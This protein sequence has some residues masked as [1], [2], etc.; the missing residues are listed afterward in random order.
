MNSYRALKAKEIELA[1]AALQERLEQCP[2]TN[3]QHVIVLERLEAL[4]ATYA[5]ELM[6]IQPIIHDAAFRSTV[7]FTLNQTSIFIFI[8]E[9]QYLRGLATPSKEE[10]FLR[11]IFLNC[12]KRLGL[13]WIEDMA[14]QGSG[15]LAIFPKFGNSLAIPAF[16]I[17]TGLL[18]SFLSLPGVYH[19]FGHSVFAR[20]PSLLAS[21]QQVVRTHFQELVRQ[22]GPMQPGIRAAQINRFQLAE[23]FWT[24]RCLEELFCD[25]FAQYIGGCANIVSMIDLSMAKGSPTYEMDS[26]SYPPDAARVRVC[27]SVLTANQATEA[28]TE[29]LL[30]EWGEYAQQ[31]SDS[32]LYRDACSENLLGQFGQVAFATL[33]AEMP[34]LPKSEIPPPD[35]QTAF[36]PTT[37]IFFED[38]IQHGCAVL[39]WRRDNFESWWQDIQTRLI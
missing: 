24:D 25:L 3:G 29:Y 32:Q 1:L 15:E 10:L 14:V 30:K 39:S 11:S 9:M 17:P 20:F 5:N 38:A 21:M 13:D 22:L 7:D 31:F 12:V 36:T 2:R 19:E 26:P 4:L 33:A 6:I 28:S 8:V 27:A 23:E 18:D 16:H 37:S 35:V 34:K